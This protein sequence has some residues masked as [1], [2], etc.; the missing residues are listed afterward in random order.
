MKITLTIYTEI[1]NPLTERFKRI[2]V[3]KEHMIV[4]VFKHHDKVMFIESLKL[5]KK[6]N[7]NIKITG[8]LSYCEII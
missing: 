6:E 8:K 5:F 7:P 2:I 4:D 1:N 3:H